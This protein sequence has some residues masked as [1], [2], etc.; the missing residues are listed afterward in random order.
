MGLCDFTQ[1][2]EAAQTRIRMFCAH[3]FNTY[4]STA[5][6][7]LLTRY[8]LERKVP[9]D[10]V[11]CGVAAGAQ[12]GAMAQAVA[13]LGA[14]DRQLHGYDSFDGIPHAGPHDDQQPG[15]AHFLMDRNLPLETRLTSTGISGCPLDTVKDLWKRWNFKVKIEWHKGWF[16]DTLPSC[17]LE[18]IAFLRLDGDLYE[19]TWCCLENLYSRVSPG[20][21]IFIDD[22]GLGGCQKAVRE[23][24]QFLKEV[25][26]VP[27]PEILI[28]KGLKDG[29]DSIYWIK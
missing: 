18:S 14:Y 2:S 23:F 29:G 15:L 4:Q 17:T 24:W 20:G 27:E 6:T 25:Q 21:I 12:L 7:Y 8:L 16:Q 9:G 1:I 28:D 10:L 22:W 13:D 3:A 5:Q 19:S 11:E 26:Q